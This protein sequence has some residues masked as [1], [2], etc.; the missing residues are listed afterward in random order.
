MWSEADP[1]VS[2]C[3]QNALR[4]ARHEALVD[5][6]C[7]IPI[8]LQHSSDDDNVPVFHARRMQEI[9]SQKS[10]SDIVYSELDGKG[11]WFDGV[12]TTPQ[13][14]LFYKDILSNPYMPVL[15]TSFS[16]CVSDPASMGSRGGVRV[17]LLEDPD[18][19]G[20][21]SVTRHTQGS[22]WSVHLRGGSFF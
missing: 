6:F 13:L 8:F 16:V 21:I 11:H 9:V 15:P 19:M 17:D 22:T 10:N 1:R 2:L 18:Q 20:S 4:N 14:C 12:L 7:N 5:N 3:I